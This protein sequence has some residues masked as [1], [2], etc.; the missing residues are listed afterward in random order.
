VVD[1]DRRTVAIVVDDPDVR[2]SL[3]FL[4]EVI[5]HPVRAFAST[6]E[7]LRADIRHIACLILD[8][9]M[10][11]MTGLHLA[12]RLRNEGSLMPIMLITGS[13]SP[14]I[15]AQAARLGIHKVLEK[16][17]TDS[18]L[19]SFIETSLQRRLG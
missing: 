11:E 10:P 19:V 16:P 14:H 4:L 13:L 5:G 1:R 9:H 15:T 2:S 17:P 18:D 8:H 6:A 7:F 3:V 12:E